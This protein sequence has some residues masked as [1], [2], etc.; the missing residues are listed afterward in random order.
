MQLRT[1]IGTLFCL[2][3]VSGDAF[4]QILST[5][6]AVDT[7]HTFTL[8][9]VSVMTRRPLIGTAIEA[10]A[11]QRL[12]IHRVPEAI[13][14]IPG[15]TL[16]EASSRG[17]TQLFL[18]GF[19]Q[20]RVPVFMDGIPIYVP[21]DSYIDLGR[22]QTA[23]ISRIEVSKGTSS[24]LL[25]G[26]TMG[27]AVNII[28]SQ[29]SERLEVA[30]QGSTLWN[31]S[32]SVGTKQKYWYARLDGS[33]IGRN[34]FRLPSHFQAV[35][36]LQESRTRQHSNT[37]D[38]QLGAKLGITPRGT[39]EYV[40]GYSLI[41]ADKYVPPYLGEQGKPRF[42]RYKDWDKDLAYFHS[43]TR[44][45]EG[46]RLEGRAFYD[47]YYNLLKAYDDIHYHTQDTK[48]GFDSYYNDYSLGAGASLAWQAA[49][50]HEVKLGANLKNDV[51]RSHD[52]EDPQA[53]QS[54]T[55]TS[56]A[57]EDSWYINNHWAVA[58]SI[59]YFMHQGHTIELYEQLPDSKEMGI[60][61]YPASTDN[62]VNYQLSTDWRPSAHH[63]LRFSFSR[64]SRFASL[65]DRYSYK[66]G[67]AL[68]NPHL[69]TE[70]SY[71]FDLTYNGQA[72]GWRWYAST[73]YMVLTNTIQEITGI[74]PDD[75]KVWQLQNRG[76]AH[77][78]GIELGLNYEWRWLE[79]ETNYSYIHRRNCSNPEL[80]F[81]DVPE[82]TLNARLQVTPIWDIH[83]Q[84]TLQARSKA[85][86]SSDG[87]TYAP[88]FGVVNVTISKTFDALG[89]STASLNVRAGI[90]NLFDKLYYYSEGFPMEGRR[91]YVSAAYRFSIK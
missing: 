39:D 32:L 74:D 37:Q 27:G 47:R 77:Y 64:N 62:D 7:T 42:W 9:E 88:G 50:G 67:K 49:H 18:R 60:V 6:H 72:A 12:E 61:N 28:S 34:D 21:Y 4:A 8:G 82:S 55:M 86:S 78:R 5:E 63:A 41:R 31:S 76:R 23:S 33:W 24:F 15:V 89:F 71:N 91:F 51:H 57:L 53:R 90:N 35:E 36:G 44:L 68:P 66:R 10:T 46:W 22:L 52:D 69:K 81:L 70:H 38:W 87:S 73:Y 80:K 43:R 79:V 40:I 59:G 83:L 65:K 20:T 48:N 19:D 2:S 75:P 29:P 13:S 54:E 3:A 17:E 11:L 26:N 14:W 56:F 45:A 85:W 1:L 58:G 84:G 30:V 25:G 16:T